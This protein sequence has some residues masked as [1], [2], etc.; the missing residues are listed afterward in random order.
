MQLGAVP[1]DVLAHVDAT[2]A[3]K[4][5]MVIAVA[6]GAG[7]ELVSTGEKARPPGMAPGMAS[8]MGWSTAD[9]P[10]LGL[11]TGWKLPWLPG[12]QLEKL[13]YFVSPQF[14]QVSAELPVVDLAESS[15][16]QAVNKWDIRFL[17]PTFSHLPIHTLRVLHPSMVDPMMAVGDV[18]LSSMCLSHFEINQFYCIITDFRWLAVIVSYELIH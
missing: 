17:H 5:S 9:V 7:Q 12:D 14:F 11:S 13:F 18:S 10:S 2:L 3:R 8:G 16:L 6:E 15:T 4:G 1:Q